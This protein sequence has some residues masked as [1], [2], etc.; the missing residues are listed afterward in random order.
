M[1]S[2]SGRPGGSGSSGG[3]A[4][5]A[6]H[7][8]PSISR[9]A[10]L[11]S[12][13]QHPVLKP[14]TRK[15]SS[16]DTMYDTV[17]QT[18][19]GFA[20]I[21]RVYL[22]AD[23]G[24]APS[25]T[26]HGVRASHD[27]LDIRMKVIGYGPISTDQGW[28]A[29]N[30]K[31]GDAV[32]AVIHHFQ[33]KPPSISEI[34]DAN[35]R[36]LQET[37]SGPSNNLRS[38]APANSS[39][40][41]HSASDS[42]SGPSHARNNSLPNPPAYPAQG[43]PSHG[44]RS[45]LPHQPAVG[46]KPNFDPAD[47]EVDALIPPIPSSFLEID[48]LPLSGL[49]QLVEDKAALASFVENRPGVKTLTELKQSVETANVTAAKANLEHQDELKGVRSE[50][51]T[52]QKDLTAKIEKYRALD[53]ERKALTQPPDR[54]EAIS[55]L[56]RAKREAYRESEQFADEWVDSGGEDVSAF[57]KQFMEVR[58]LYHTRAAKAERLETSM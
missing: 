44:R 6:A 2:W 3:G 32:Y 24:R 41:P 56:N 54:Q 14:S 11:A 5:S 23:A 42:F 21:V 20:L 46:A 16:D 19:N 49:T 48:N 51:D 39:E 55:E 38:S 35:L 29:A 15:V 7:S 8:G 52:L 43:G 9:S 33:L 50:V 30:M 1:F 18:T 28:R 31:L 17:F 26:L 36:R 37:L 4:P 57:V 10:H 47:D 53:D 45:S 13:L 12:Y 25:M 34:T 27:W 40:F 58:L 22:P